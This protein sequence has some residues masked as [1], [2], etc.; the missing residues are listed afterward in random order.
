ANAATVTAT[1]ATVYVDNAAIINKA[2]NTTTIKNLILPQKGKR[3]AIGSNIVIKRET[4]LSF[5]GNGCTFFSPEGAPSANFKVISSNGTTIENFTLHGNGRFKG[6]AF[7]K[8]SFPVGGAFWENPYISVG[9]VQIE[10]STA[11]IGKR[12]VVRD[13]L[14]YSIQL[15]NAVNCRFENCDVYPP[16]SLGYVGWQVHGYS[17]KGGGFYSTKIHA[18]T[19]GK[20]CSGFEFFGCTNMIMKD[21]KGENVVNAI[22]GSSNIKISGASF[23]IQGNTLP[24]WMNM[25]SPVWDLNGQYAGVAFSGIEISDMNI[26]QL[27]FQKGNQLF[28]EIYG[29]DLTPNISVKNYKGNFP[30][31]IEGTNPH[32]SIFLWADGA[33]VENAVIKGKYP[34]AYYLAR[35][36]AGAQEPYT[37]GANIALSFAAATGKGLGKGYIRNSTAEFI[38]ITEGI[39]LRNNTTKNIFIAKPN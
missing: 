23:T 33:K 9:G 13:V 28:H 20:L 15:G 22:N 18:P 30:N 35:G 5:D 37:Y 4:P 10:N 6:F 24:T 31:A 26:T 1:N 14:S 2:L 29:R 32:V 36:T 16:E 21:I 38:F 25:G 8:N 12:I 11:S 17:S 3:Y 19:G 39:E 34:A 27:G 7:P